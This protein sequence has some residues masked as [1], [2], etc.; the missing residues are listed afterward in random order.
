MEEGCA[1]LAQRFG[2]LNQLNKYVCSYNCIHEEMGLIVEN[3]NNEKVTGDVNIRRKIN[4]IKSN[5]S[6]EPFNSEFNKD[7]VL[8]VAVAP[9]DY[10]TVVLLMK[11]GID[12][13]FFQNFN[14]SL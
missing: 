4:Y 7:N 9:G 13:N 3:I 8:E 1:D 6:I 2:T 10:Y 11:G 14:F 12:R 5:L